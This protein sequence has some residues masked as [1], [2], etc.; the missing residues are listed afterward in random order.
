MSKVITFSCP[1]ARA[2]ASAGDDAGGG[3]R[4]ERVDRA[5]A[6]ASSAVITPP[7]DC[8]IVSGASM[9]GRVEPAPDVADVARPSA[10]GRTR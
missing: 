4:L 6:A 7:D 3:A 5:A 8:M 2:S 10:A 9:P 1:S